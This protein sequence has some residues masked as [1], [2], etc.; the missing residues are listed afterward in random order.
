M[1][2][3]RF[4]LGGGSVEVATPLTDEQVALLAGEAR[5]FFRSGGVLSWRE[6]SD[7][8]SETRAMFMRARAEA[9]TE[10]MIGFAAVLFPAAPKPRAELRD[11]DAV[12]SALDAAERR[13]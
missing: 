12:S 4:L 11:E 3:D 7:M 8:G 2:P 5:G 10:R 9:E 6:W 13:P 1:K